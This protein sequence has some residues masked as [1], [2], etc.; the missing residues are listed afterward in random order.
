M[1]DYKCSNCG[2]SA[3]YLSDIK[4]FKTP[5]S[6]GSPILVDLNVTCIGLAKAQKEIRENGNTKD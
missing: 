4:E 2:M 5:C 6:C 3:I 1:W